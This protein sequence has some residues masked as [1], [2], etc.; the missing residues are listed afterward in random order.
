[1]QATLPLERL[2]VRRCGLDPDVRLAG[3]NPKGRWRTRAARR[4]P[5][6]TTKLAEALLVKEPPAVR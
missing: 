5:R 3:V 2:P 4:S 1:A 6:Y